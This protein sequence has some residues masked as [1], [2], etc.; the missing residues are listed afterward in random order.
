[1]EY[2][3]EKAQGGEIAEHWLVSV[4]VQLSESVL[5]GELVLTVSDHDP[6]QPNDPSK[7]DDCEWEVT[8]RLAVEPFVSGPEGKRFIHYH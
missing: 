1:M 8:S 2:P 7:P 6:Q 3:K 4:S 5:G